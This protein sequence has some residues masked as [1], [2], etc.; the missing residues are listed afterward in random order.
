MYKVYAELRDKAG[1]SDYAVAKATE[2]PAS[3]LSDWKNGLYEPKVD[4]LM[5]LAKFFNVPIEKF[6]EAKQKQKLEEDAEAV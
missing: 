4:K 3:T 2:I 6:L 1:L 5:A